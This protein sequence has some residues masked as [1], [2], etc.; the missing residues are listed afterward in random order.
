MDHRPASV[1]RSQGVEKND[2]EPSSGWMRLRIIEPLCL[3]FVIHI[4]KWETDQCFAAFRLFGDVAIP[5]AVLLLMFFL[6]YFLLVYVAALGMT[7]ECGSRFRA[8]LSRSGIRARKSL[9]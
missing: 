2:G 7:N 5:H 6:F 8:A 9:V 1:K 4:V 3:P